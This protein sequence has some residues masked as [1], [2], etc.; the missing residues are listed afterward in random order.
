MCAGST[1]RKGRTGR[2]MGPEGGLSGEAEVGAAG[3]QAEEDSVHPRE[4]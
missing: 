3:V 1:V 2:E 4:K